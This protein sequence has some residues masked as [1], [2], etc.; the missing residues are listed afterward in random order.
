[1]SKHVAVLMGGWSAE[2]EVSLVSGKACAEALEAEGY[3][4]SIIDPPR[5]LH[6]IANALCPRNGGKSPDV[7][8]NAL[9]GRYG[10]DGTIQAVLDIARIPYTHSG[11]MSSAIAMNK[12]VALNIFRA[13]GIPVAEG[14]VVP[15]DQLGK[16]DP[17][18]RPYVV[19][20][21]REGSSVGVYIVQDGDNG[22]EYSGWKYGDALVEEYIPGREL[23]VSV[24]GDE[25][26]GVTELR[27]LSGFYDYENKYTD[28]CTE[29]LCPA[30]VPE[31]IKD[32]CQQYAIKAHK[33]LGCDGVSR[34]DFRYDDTQSGVERLV[35]L[36]VNTQPGMT[37]LSLV[38]E[39]A[40][41]MG[42][43]FGKLVSW[44]VENARCPD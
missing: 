1:M 37:P 4:V 44:M 6:E 27:P 22:P 8:F 12:P 32:Q 34:S 19:K 39:Q 43:P 7:V 17:M 29:H 38:P 10:E 36:E 18:Q 21:A 25:A 31:K 3:D 16:G 15:P 5:D 9:H 40:E 41:K 11:L 30:P 28:G 23:T 2:R 33:L 24:I 35:L 14:R 42:M 20:P 13:A 26:L